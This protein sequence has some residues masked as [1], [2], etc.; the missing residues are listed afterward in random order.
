MLHYHNQEKRGVSRPGAFLKDNKAY[1]TYNG[2]FVVFFVIACE[3][4]LLIRPLSV[5][6]NSFYRYSGI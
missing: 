3:I 4:V 6:K 1:V 2:C 5:F